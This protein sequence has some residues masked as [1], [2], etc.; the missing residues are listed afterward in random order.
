MVRDSAALENVQLDGVNLPILPDDR[1]A[2]NLA[3]IFS[4]PATAPTAANPAGCLAA[5]ITI[6][7]VTAAL[8]NFKTDRISPS[9][10]KMSLLKL[11][12]VFNLPKSR[13]GGPGLIQALGCHSGRG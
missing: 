12:L 4:T 7:P 13:L 3:A 9:T 10:S 11:S 2:A 5:P 6:D 1:S 8:V